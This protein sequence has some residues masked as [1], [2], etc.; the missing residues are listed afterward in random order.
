MTKTS[1]IDYGDIQGLLRFGYGHLKEACF[2]MLRVEDKAAACSWLAT[3]PVTTA[4]KL[5]T[6]PG[7]AL[8]VA[9]TSQ[10]LTALGVSEDIVG[11]FSPEFISGIAGDESRSRRLGDTGT[12][13]PCEWQW[14]GPGNTPDVMVMLFADNG[15]LEDLKQTLI[16]G[17]RDGGFRLLNG[18]GTSDLDGYEPF[19]FRDGISQPTI[20]W[21]RER[22]CDGRDELEYSNLLALGEF[23]LGYPNEYGK[24]TDRPLLTPSQDARGELMD[25]EDQPARKDLGRNGSYLVFRQLRQNVRGFWQF[26]D[27]EANSNRE[28]MKNVAAKIVGRTLDG[29][30][31]VRVT[32]RQIRG[33][34]DQEDAAPNQFTFDSDKTGARCPFGAHIR[35]VNPRNGDLPAG[36]TGL[37]SR[38]I[39]SLGLGRRAF[40]DDIIASTRF[41]RIL[42]RGREYGPGLSLE[43]ALRPEPPNDNERGLHFICLNANIARQFEFVQNAWVIN[44]KFDG[45]SE[46]SDPLLGTR[47]PITGCDFTNR[48]SIPLENGLSRRITALPRFVTVCGGAY[49]F[50]PGIRALR[51]LAHVGA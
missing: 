10:G 47:E 31:L 5:E 44:T 38:L 6:P 11:G 25:A 20:D 39:R 8:Q 14:G 9:L 1:A 23:V 17:L 19:G 15:C 43:E 32:D 2:M 29:S 45:L 41:H 48:F 24:Y 46:E 22:A 4:E 7:T 21:N 36:T 18:L 26:L 27:R 16:G 35:R 50:L 49:F 13:A 30:P 33:V 34:A 12:S 51:F 28:E 37:F 40:R 42:R 3:A